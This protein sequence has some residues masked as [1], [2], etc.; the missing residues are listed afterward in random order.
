[1]RNRRLDLVDINEQIQND[2][3]YNSEYNQVQ[4]KDIER[5]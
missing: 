4:V 1:M 5:K 3:Q 2:S